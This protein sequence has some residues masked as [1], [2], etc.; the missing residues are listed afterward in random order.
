MEN[1]P[2]RHRT[3]QGRHVPD[4]MAREFDEQVGYIDNIPE[5]PDESE[6]LPLTKGVNDPVTQE[7]IID[8]LLMVRAR[9]LFV[10]PQAREDPAASRVPNTRGVRKPSTSMWFK[11][12]AEDF[13]LTVKNK[14]LITKQRQND[15]RKR[16][17]FAAELPSPRKY[18]ELYKEACADPRTRPNDEFVKSDKWAR[19]AR[20]NPAWQ[21]VENVEDG[22]NSLPKST[23]KTMTPMMHRDNCTNYFIST[24]RERTD[25]RTGLSSKNKRCPLQLEDCI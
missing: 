23:F 24:L 18:T 10:Q 12:G 22:L 16:N 3:L 20:T 19:K 5:I 13:N 9:T 4:Y 7:E 14:D 17:K 1:T 2:E 15:Q 8:H 21:S 25:D 6:L 11:P